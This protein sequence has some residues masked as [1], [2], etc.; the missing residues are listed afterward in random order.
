MKKTALIIL[1]AVAALPA[2][3]FDVAHG[4]QTRNEAIVTVD[5]S[6]YQQVYYRPLSPVFSRGG[7]VTAVTGVPSNPKLFYMGA[8]GG[9]VW[10]T[11]DSGARW[12]PLTDGQIGVGT[13]GAID[14]ALSD[15]NVVYMGTG[16]A[17]PRGNVTN[18]DGV[19]KSTDAG[20]TWT[21][22]GL[23]KAGLVGRIR[24]HPTDPNIA[25]VAALGN[26]FGPNPERGVYRTK[27][28]GATWEQVL[29]VSPRTGA[30]DVTMDVKNPGTLLASMWTVERK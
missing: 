21:R 4:W 18:G 20:K 5:P 24:I 3:P 17:D 15:P 28:G 14:V 19:Y 27:D 7:R 12:E 2:A 8:A 6:L 23:E 11:I 22:A 10:K 16:S 1:L 29:K 26:I 30:I 25:F 9:G 13:I